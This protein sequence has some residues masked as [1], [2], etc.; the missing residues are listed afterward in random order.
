[1]RLARSSGALLFLLPLVTEPHR[2]EHVVGERTS[3]ACQASAVLEVLDRAGAAY[4]PARGLE[5]SLSFRLGA[6]LEHFLPQTGA[7]GEVGFQACGLL[8]ASRWRRRPRRDP[9]WGV[10]VEQV[11]LRGVLKPLKTGA[12]SRKEVFEVF[13]VDHLLAHDVAARP[14]FPDAGEILAVQRLENLDDAPVLKADQV[15]A[16][17]RRRLGRERPHLLAQLLDR[18]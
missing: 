3:Q 16:P 14:V 6:G 5:R 15:A 11:G 12:G 8:F 13:R 7:L 18:P 17:N 1:G 2:V 9:R 10:R 4:R